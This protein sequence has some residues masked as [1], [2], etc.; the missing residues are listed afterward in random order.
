MLAGGEGV[1]VLPV[2]SARDAPERD[3][4]RGIL[5]KLDGS[6]SADEGLHACAQVR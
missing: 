6:H 2:T 4:E 5:K 3:T 1:H